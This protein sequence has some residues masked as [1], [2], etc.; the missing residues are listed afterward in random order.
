M[1]E[2][3]GSNE[4]GYFLIGSDESLNVTRSFLLQ[5][6]RLYDVTMTLKDAQ[7]L[8]SLPAQTDII[9]VA[10]YLTFK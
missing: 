9:P 2:N 3:V 10:G 1:R 5:D 4:E 6:V 7:E 8:Y